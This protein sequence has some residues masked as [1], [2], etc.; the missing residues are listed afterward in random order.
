MRCRQR[1][2]YDARRVAG[3]RRR[4]GKC[5]E[6]IRRE[7]RVHGKRHRIL[8]IDGIV[9]NGEVLHELTDPAG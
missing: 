9:F 5:V 3:Q 4:G 1:I 6:L 2:D 7:E 8:S